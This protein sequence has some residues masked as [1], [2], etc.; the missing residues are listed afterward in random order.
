MFNDQL[1]KLEKQKADLAVAE[2]KLA[3]DRLAALSKLPA[4]Y[5]YE[6][7][8]T[9]I[10]AVKLAASSKSLSANGKTSVQAKSTSLK[11]P[12]PVKQYKAQRAKITEE[13]KSHV[14]AMAEAGKTGVEIALALNISQPTV[15][16]IKKALGL[17]K[18]RAAGPL[19]GVS[20]VELSVAEATPVAAAVVESAA[21]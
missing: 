16:N 19:D 17:V 12:K 3:A 2:A 13:I 18:A 1:A 8:D 5:G 10:K 15:Q 9:F 6:N 7:V 11:A 21:V 20:V 14:K 4:D